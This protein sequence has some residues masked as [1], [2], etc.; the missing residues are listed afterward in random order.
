GALARDELL[1]DARQRGGAHAVPGHEH[2]RGQPFFLVVFHEADLA[3]RCACATPRSTVRACVASEKTHHLVMAD[4]SSRI[5]RRQGLVGAAA[6][7]VAGA[8][9]GAEAQARG[10]EG[11]GPMT[12]SRLPVIY[13]PHGGGPWPFVDVGF[14]DPAEYQR[15]ASYLRGLGT[16]RP[17]AV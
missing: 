7:A 10:R 9:A 14:G 13:L 12:S 11:H 15:L 17:R 4:E 8:S 3:H 6:A 2:V 16:I 5:T 1:D